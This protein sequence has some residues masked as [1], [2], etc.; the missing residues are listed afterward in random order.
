MTSCQH[1][2]LKFITDAKLAVV[3][4]SCKGD[5]KGGVVGADIDIWVDGNYLLDS[6]H[7]KKVS[8][9]WITERKC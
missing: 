5:H 3:S 2:E 1:I 4:Y 9:A 6:C 8:M 7:W